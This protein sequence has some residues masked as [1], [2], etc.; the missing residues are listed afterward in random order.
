MST[1]I[2]VLR[3]WW[4]GALL[5]VAGLAA[6]PGD[7]RLLDAVENG[8][9]EAV[10][11]LLRENVDVNA[12]RA[13][14]ATA[15]AWAA[16]R[17][18]LETAEL[19]IRAGA[20]VNAANEYGVTP[21]TLACTNGS[22]A[23]VDT[24]LK[25]GANPNAALPAGETAL[26]ACARTGVPDAVKLLLARGADVN[27]KET[28]RGQTALMW[29]LED[30]HLEVARVL[31][32][33][34]AN[35]HARSKGGFTPLVLAAR[36]CDPASV[37]TLL[38]AGANVNEATLD[39]ITPL[40]A[41]SANGCEALSTFLLEKG[42]DPNAADSYGATALHYALLKGIVAL[43]NVP[44]TV[45]AAYLF[46]PNMTE[47]VKA[48]LARGANP[49]ARLLK[50]LRLRTS[51][52]ARVSMVG[53]TPFLLATSSLDLDLMRFLV[54]HGAD[55]LLGTVENTTPL[56]IAAGLGY[57]FDRT[58][59]EKKVAL[60]AAKLTI[61]LGADVNAVGENGWTP[62]HGAAYPGEDAIVQLLV[63]NGA[64]LDAKDKWKQTPLSIA[65][66]LLSPLMLNFTK[67]PYS[68]HPSTVNLLL[69][70]GAP[71]WVPPAPAEI[72]P[73]PL[74]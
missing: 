28:R 3:G 59:D 13:D 21:L 73:S 60:E 46:R 26:M 57:Y 65:Q 31:I 20:S 42:A 40:L 25:A 45:V 64:K 10:R 44:S 4:M 72:A 15:L 49:N 5:S 23:M 29:A 43:D 54:E 32:E 8:D 14:G 58:E 6:T 62:L 71:P 27:A 50:G 18:D 51:F 35:V 7:L 66:G 37:Q 16:H 67:K 11:S 63:D 36:E 74:K 24:L 55:P 70:L 68:A 61:A 17:D 48:L 39:G 30:K 53:A 41:A 1:T 52:S 12:S 22:A 33:H 38:E 19:L 2:R 34:G 69:K 56:M 47:L 9:K